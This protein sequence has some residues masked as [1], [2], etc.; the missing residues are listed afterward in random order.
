[1]FG[2]STQV[3]V[4]DKQDLLERLESLPFGR[5]HMLLIGLVFGAVA[6]DNMDQATLS[7][8]IPAYSREWGLTPTITRLNPIMGIT[9]TLIGAVLG[10]LLADRIGRRKT[11]NIM[12]LIFAATELVNGFAQSFD[13]VVTSCF[14]MGIGVGGA[15]PV[16]FSIISEFT[17]ASK[18][19]AVQII[20]GVV[21]IG[22][23]YIIASASA[24]AFLDTLGWR[25]LFGIGVIPAFLV[26]LMY[27][28]CPESP[29]Y[30]LK[31]G[32]IQQAVESVRR[33]EQLSGVGHVKEL[34][35]NKYSVNTETETVGGMA[36]LWSKKFRKVSTLV[37]LYGALWGFFN[38]GLL[39]WLP[40]IL[41]THFD[42]TS[43]STAYFT[44]VVDLAGIPVGFLTAYVFDKLGRKPILMLYSVLSGVAVLL[45]GLLGVGGALAPALFVA[46]GFVIYSTGFA[47]AG[48]FPPYA[49]ELYDTDVRATGAG[50]AVAISRVT[51]VTSIFVIGGLL[52]SNVGTPLIF[53]LL[54]APLILAGI[55]VHMLGL[56]TKG[57]VL[58]KIAPQMRG[59]LTIV[60]CKGL[61]ESAV[62]WEPTN[63]V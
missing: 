40:T 61:Q 15:V 48:M 16:A 54:G 3:N 14:V 26:P 17:P 45:M 58:E 46:I 23:G 29:R 43:H 19:G 21:S 6:F 32:R 44:S 52:S 57:I 22:G 38:F 27:K 5:F 37:W 63:G 60:R 62:A 12:I 31:K 49:S 47:L 4:P 56:E 8:V 24:N 7:F 1:L 59:T 28:F 35:V 42:Y 55:V 50:W 33:V 34:Y 20:T 2:V 36:K 9:G 30:Y 10:G 25:F 39:V 13:W 51:G 18:R 11:F 53:G 41:T